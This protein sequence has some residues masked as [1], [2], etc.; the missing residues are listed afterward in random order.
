MAYFSFLDSVIEEGPRERSWSGCLGDRTDSFLGR[1]SFHS[2]SPPAR[3]CVERGLS[4]LTDPAPSSLSSSWESP[5]QPQ[6]PGS[7]IHPG[8]SRFWGSRC[9]SRL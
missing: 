7:F 8:S 5:V 9:C 2:M 1:L 4:R 6:T 3:V